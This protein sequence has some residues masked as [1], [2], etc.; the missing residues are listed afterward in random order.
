[1]SDKIGTNHIDLSERLSKRL[2]FTSFKTRQWLLSWNC[3]NGESF[4]W[5]TW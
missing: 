5:D 1:M 4:F 3:S 2:P